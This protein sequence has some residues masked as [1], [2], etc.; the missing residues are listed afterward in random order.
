[1]TDPDSKR[2]PQFFS[3]TDRVA[4][5]R[6]ALQAAGEATHFVPAE[7]GYIEVPVVEL[8]HRALLYRADNGRVL[9]ELADVA[10]AR[11]T[12][13]D[14]LKASAENPEV[15]Q[16][17]H[18]LLIAKARDP[19]GPIYSELKR[20]GRQT[21]PLL[22]RKDG[23]VLNGNRRL[24]AMRELNASDGE[25]YAQFDRVRAA[26]LP[27]GLDRHEI[28][29][30]EAALQ[31]AP[32]LKLDYGWIN[33]R[34][35]LRQHAA[36]M[37]TERVVAAYRFSDTSEIDRELGELALAEAYL[38]WVGRPGDF[39]LVAEQE[40]AFIALHSQL[41]A[42]AR[43][44]PTDIWR[45]IGFAMLKAESELDL[46]IMHYFPFTD[47][48]PPAMRNW[49]P[50]SLAE[51][52]GIVER[53]TEGENRRLDDAAAHRLLHSLDDPRQAKST[54][55]ASMAL[56]DTL[57]GEQNRMIGFARLLAILRNANQT[58]QEI[59]PDDLTS[60]QMRR[61]RAEIAALQHYTDPMM[62]PNDAHRHPE[63]KGGYG[64]RKAARKTWKRAKRVFR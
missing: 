51:D 27:D 57:K 22:I 33:R 9:S 21:E 42:M 63:P 50:R 38:E 62:R 29:F 52:A 17:L 40:K 43:S 24:A 56:I 30:I 18:G 14:D 41:E 59:S 11:G 60:D 36:D 47:P 15:Q 39:A 49:V 28:E 45:G 61:L 5:I 4:M 7:S 53:Q 48:V 10:R 12:S 32:D 6:Q 20:H 58:L 19:R 3:Q 1:M 44:H 37:G 23:I 16:I 55:L 25:T 34:L 26:V 13:I 2:P 31:M 8:D 54:A 64:L 46:N 35:K